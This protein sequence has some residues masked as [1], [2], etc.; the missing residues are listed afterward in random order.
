M[1]KTEAQAII[2]CLQKKEMTPEDTL[3]LNGYRVPLIHQSQSRLTFI[4][5]LNSNYTLL[6]ASLETIHV[7]EESLGARVQPSSVRGVQCMNIT[8]PSVLMLRGTILKIVKSCLN[9]AP[10]FLVRL[11]TFWMSL[12]GWHI[13]INNIAAKKY[14]L[15]SVC[16]VRRRLTWFEAF[17]YW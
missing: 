4:C 17:C 14:W 15:V 5:S 2:K 3:A 8:W 6:V 7:V 1:D 10:P 11:R 16:A 9:C 13:W 12:V